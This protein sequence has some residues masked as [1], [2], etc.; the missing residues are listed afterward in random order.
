VKSKLSARHASRYHPFPYL[1]DEMGAALRSADLAISR[2][3]ASSLGEYPA[4]ELPAIL[5]PYPYAWRYQQVNARY[6]AQRGAALVIEDADLRDHLPDLALEL[7]HDP[8]KLQAM[9]QA[10]R[11]LARPNAAGAIAG[12][13]F[14]IVQTTGRRGVEP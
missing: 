9:R 2:A 4:F 12:L 6:L 13:L 10:M 14:S 5:V 8:E 7:I 1:H 3:G 11:S